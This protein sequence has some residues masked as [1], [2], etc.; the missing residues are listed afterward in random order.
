MFH[1]QNI[2]MAKL[3]AEALGIPHMEQAPEGEKEKELKDLETALERAK[4][5]YKIEGV[6][7][8][9]LFSTYQKERIEKV[10]EKL[11]LIAV[12]P[13]WHKSQ[14]QMMRD[15]IEKFEIVFSSV[16]AEGLDASWLGRKI[17]IEDVNSLIELNRKSGINVA[18]EGGEFESLVLDGPLF[19]KRIKIDDFEM[20]EESKNTAGMVVKKAKLV[21]K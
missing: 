21:N 7:T 14:I 15:V 3:Q 13:L 18:G 8:G 20:T 1:T 2:G 10:C 5:E 16:A 9:A 12:S 17:T 6:V 19:K 11:G 4:E